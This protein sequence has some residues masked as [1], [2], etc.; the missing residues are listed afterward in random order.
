MTVKLD[1][2]GTVLKTL[3]LKAGNVTEACVAAKIS[4]QTFY[5]WRKE[6]PEFDQ[7]VKDT[8]ESNK[9]LFE[10]LLLTQGKK[11]NV[12]AILGWLNANAKDRGY[13]LNRMEHSGPEGGPIVHADLSG[14]TPAEIRKIIREEVVARQGKR[15]GA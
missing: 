12:T 10:G 1:D 3:V 8:R 11:G 7:A 2:K 4:R 14:K 15:T 5:R 13:G 9:D 6:D